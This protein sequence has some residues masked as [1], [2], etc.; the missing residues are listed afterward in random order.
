MLF[1]EG[2]VVLGFGFF[3]CFEYCQQVVVVVVFEFGDVVCVLLFGG[4]FYYLV[5]QGFG[6]FWCWQVG[7]G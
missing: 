5:D 3:D 2:E 7:L 1:G 6:E 4:V